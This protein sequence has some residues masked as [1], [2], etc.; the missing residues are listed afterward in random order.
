MDKY[1]VNKSTCKWEKL[2]EYKFQ[3]LKKDVIDKVRHTEFFEQ[4]NESENVACANKQRGG[5][6]ELPF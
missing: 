2:A 5:V 4:D 3:R 1:Y 6:Y